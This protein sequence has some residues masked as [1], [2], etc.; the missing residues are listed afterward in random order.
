VAGGAALLRE[1]RLASGLPVDPAS[2]RAALLRGAMD[3]GDPGPDPSFG[4]GQVR[5]DKARPTLR[6]WLSAGPRRALRVRAS[7]RGTLRE[8]R[9][10]LDGR[11]LRTA[12]RPYARVQLP[13]LPPGRHELRLEAE[14]MAGNV[15]VRTRII[16]G[17]R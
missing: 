6:M 13:G 9:V 8:L 4:A 3:L 2:L 15:A 5:L 11:L 17:T 14:D 1:M 10:A 16:R 7:D 12:R